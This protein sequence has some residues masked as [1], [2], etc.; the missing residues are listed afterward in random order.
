MWQLLTCRTEYLCTFSTLSV[1]ISTTIKAYLCQIIYFIIFLIYTPVLGR[2]G[3]I[4][5]AV[6]FLCAHYYSYSRFHMTPSF[7]PV[8]N[9]LLI[10]YVA[11]CYASKTNRIKATF[12]IDFLF[13]SNHR[14]PRE[15]WE[16]IRGALGEDPGGGLGAPRGAAKFRWLYRT[17]SISFDLHTLSAC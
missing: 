15:A 2:Y 17:S 8:F 9:G 16:R 5:G 14:E 6:L 7:L 3:E 1:F 10:I 13:S 4:R 11:V 12:A